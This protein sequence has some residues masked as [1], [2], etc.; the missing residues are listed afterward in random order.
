MAATAVRH[1]GSV[2]KTAAN[3]AAVW[4]QL[5][6]V[7]GTIAVLAALSPCPTKTDS[8]KAAEIAEINKCVPVFDVTR[9]TDPAMLKEILVPQRD[10]Q[11]KWHR[12]RECEMDKKTEIPPLSKLKKQQKA[13]LI[14]AAVTVNINECAAEISKKTLAIFTELQ[15]EKAGLTRMVAALMAVQRKGTNGD[16]DDEEND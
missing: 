1:G 9:F 8:K 12:L 3:T 6:A 16:E 14:V 5:A 10:L 13:E 2:T 15:T 4:R 11:L 7:G